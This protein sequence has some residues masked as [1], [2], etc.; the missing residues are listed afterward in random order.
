MRDHIARQ[1]QA[2]GLVLSEC[3]TGNRLTSDRIVSLFPTDWI[4]EVFPR[5]ELKRPGQFCN[6]F[7]N[8]LKPVRSGTVGAPAMACALVALF[9]EPEIAISTI[10]SDQAPTATWPDE[11]RIVS[12]HTVLAKTGHESFRRV[13]PRAQFGSWHLARTYLSCQGNPTAIATSLGCND[14]EVHR[15][16]AMG[17]KNIVTALRKA[18]EARA[19]KAF[20]AG[21]TLVDASRI[22]NV[23]VATLEALLRFLHNQLGVPTTARATC[24]TTHAPLHSAASSKRGK[25]VQHA[26]TDERRAGLIELRSSCRPLLAESSHGSPSF[27]HSWR[28]WLSDCGFCLNASSNALA[29]IGQ[30]ARSSIRDFSSGSRH[31]R[32]FSSMR[33]LGCFSASVAAVRR[34]LKA[35]STSRLCVR[36]PA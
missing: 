32:S 17:R 11:P 13:A 22:H 24:A 29:L 20:L 9:D 36:D 12:G 8:A 3:A 2:K 27:G 30:R 7:D 16:F 19:L 35:R 6:V 34:T 1:A 10:C 25:Q 4:K 18:P 28:A 21:E 14:K 5:A 26:K 15:L 23:P 33:A 31:R